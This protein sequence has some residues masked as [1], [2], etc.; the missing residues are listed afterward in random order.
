MHPPGKQRID[1]K[2]GQNQHHKAYRHRHA[3]ADTAVRP[4]AEICSM[5]RDSKFG[6]GI[7]EPPGK[8]S[9]DINK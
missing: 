6:N 5:V 2:K 4:Y 7:F 1:I 3:R 8:R 9:I